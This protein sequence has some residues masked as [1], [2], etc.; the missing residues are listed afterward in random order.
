MKVIEWMSVVN[1]EKCKA[2]RTCEKVCPVLAIRVENKTAVVDADRC[3]GCGNCEQRCPFYAINMV[4]R[5]EP[6]VIGV[7]VKD[8]DYSQITE[9]CLKAKLGTE[10]IICYCNEVRAEEVAAAIIKGAKTPEEISL[11]TGA[12]TGCTIECIEPIL[13]LLEA[14]GL[15]ATPPANGWQWYGRTPT[16]WEISGEVKAKYAKRGF[17]FDDDVKVLDEVVQSSLKKEGGGRL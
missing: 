3:V 17:H 13:R 8:V 2:C 10:Q 15:Q 12:R 14:A 11:M 16:V 7:D 6:K 9:L 4:K 1:E 5:S